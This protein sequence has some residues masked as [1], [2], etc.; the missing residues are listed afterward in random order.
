MHHRANT[1][2]LSNRASR[3][4][5]GRASRP[6][7]SQQGATDPCSLKAALTDLVPELPGGGENPHEAPMSLCLCTQRA[8]LCEQ[9]KHRCNPCHNPLQVG[10][11][12]LCGSISP[13]GRTQPCS[14]PFRVQ[15]NL[16]PIPWP[17]PSVQSL[18]TTYNLQRAPTP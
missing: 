13:S 12:Q 8:S 10:S 18:A 7:Y 14:L 16:H 17:R 15:C 9:A 6:F 1:L 4:V 2:C 5:G 3:Q 11:K